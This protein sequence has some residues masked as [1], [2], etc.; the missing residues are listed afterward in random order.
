M[1]AHANRPIYV[2]LIALKFLLTYQLRSTHLEAACS[3]WWRS[4]PV[5]KLLQFQVAA[6]ALRHWLV[7]ILL[8]Y[9]G[10][11]LYCVVIVV[12]LIWCIDFV[13]AAVFDVVGATG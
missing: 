10:I 13:I 12:M 6:K 5:T 7:R 8:F 11:Y 4:I 2:I 1:R 3:S 9:K